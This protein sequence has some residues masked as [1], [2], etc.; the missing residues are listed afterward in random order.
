MT[1]SNQLSFIHRLL[2]TQFILLAAHQFSNSTVS[3]RNGTR[4]STARKYGSHSDRHM[5]SLH[6]ATE[7]GACGHLKRSW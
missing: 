7:N 5:Q 3:A 1:D 6:G 2:T 4:S